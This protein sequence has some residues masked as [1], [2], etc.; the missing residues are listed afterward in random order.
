MMD[1]REEARTTQWASEP[2]HLRSRFTHHVHHTHGV[3]Q[4][5]SLGCG[6]EYSKAEAAPRVSGLCDQLAKAGEGPQETL[7]SG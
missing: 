6:R 3:C 5:V 4:S 2:Q 7:C 1:L